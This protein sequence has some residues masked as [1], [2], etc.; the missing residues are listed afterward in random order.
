M[1]SCLCSSSKC[2]LSVPRKEF[3]ED[4]EERCNSSNVINLNLR[5][6]A[7][8]FPTV[9]PRWDR[10]VYRVGFSIWLRRLVAFFY[11]G[12]CI[13]LLI[14]SVNSLVTKKT[15]SR[16]TVLMHISF[17]ESQP[18]KAMYKVFVKILTPYYK[19]KFE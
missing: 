8:R 4:A 3:P 16:G 15:H 17:L 9:D 13:T 5:S 7:T 12:H 11:L 2:Q 19:L 14:K 18:S 1:E 10:W 6:S